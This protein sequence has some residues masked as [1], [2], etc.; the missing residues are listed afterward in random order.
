MRVNVT[1]IPA[2]PPPKRRRFIVPGPTNVTVSPDA[3]ASR[4]SV[5]TPYITIPGIGLDAAPTRR[6]VGTVAV[7]G[8]TVT[9][10]PNFAPTRRALGLPRLVGPIYPDAAV[11]RR[12][13]GTPFINAI[14]GIAPDAATS[15]RNVGTVRVDLALSI[16]PAAAASRRNVGTPIMT[17]GPNAI[18]PGF[19]ASR[20]FVGIPALTGGD[21]TLSVNVGGS[22]WGGQVL[23]PGLTDA[24]SPVSYESS[25]PPTIT[26]QTLGRWTLQIDLFDDTGNFTPARGQTITVMENGV[27][28][29]AGCIQDL[30]WTRLMGTTQSIVY[31]ITATDKTGICDHRVIKTITY[32]AGSDGYFVINDIRQNSLNGEGILIT[33]Q[34]VPNDGSLG[35]LVA[36]LVCN[37]DYVTTKYN[38]IGTQLGLIWYVDTNGVLWFNSFLNLPS[39]PWGLVDNPSPTNYRGLLVSESNLDYAN[40]IYMVSNLSVLPGSGTGGGGGAGAGTGTNTETFVMTPGNIGVLVLGNGTTVYGVNVTQP[41]GTLYSLK[42]NG[43]TQVIVNYAQWN[44]EQPTSSPQFGPWFWLSSATGISASLIGVGGLP[45]GST[46]VVN[47][48]PAVQNAQAQVGQALAPVDPATGSVL[49]TCGSGVYELAIQTKNISTVS[50]LNNLAQAELVQRGSLPIRVT[51]QTDKP[52]LAPGQILPVHCPAVFLSHKEFLIVGAQ[53]VAV[54]GPLAFGSRFQWKID[55]VTNRDP[56]NFVQWY[57]NLLKNAS[58]ALPVYQYEEAKFA[59]APGSSLAG[60][61]STNSHPVM[62]TGQLVFIYAT[63]TVPPIDQ[64]LSLFF[65]VNGVRIPGSVSIPA[66]STANTAFSYT[67][68]DTNPLY[69]FNTAT[70]FDVVTV[71]YSYAVTGPNPTPAGSITAVLR[72][73]M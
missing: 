8:G 42:V 3:A 57:S 72:W 37:F 58:N 18:L 12:F 30:S 9:V 64:N 31:H 6:F 41:I 27:K 1:R 5:G 36:D 55:A 56:G 28:L 35:V 39:S 63:A 69:V 13:V 10:S 47:Y 59:L 65:F 73:R 14:S 7:A 60:L 21:P 62:R 48:T 61:L 70:E 26:S 2:P 66:G 22:L 46:V 34:S 40:V 20:R 4:R 19:A 52:G 67:F 32:P 71:G 45:S 50:D 25:S 53:G 29:F 16:A 51:F 54:E 44:G 49:G 15:R 33:P 24:G 68:P 43:V 17:G 11:S 23:C 38:E